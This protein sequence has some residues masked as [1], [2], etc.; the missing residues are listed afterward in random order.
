MTEDEGRSDSETLFEL[1]EKLNEWKHLRDLPAFQDF[2][3]QI[4]GQVEGREARILAMEVRSVEDVFEL[5]M[6]KGERAGMKLVS[7]YPDA[8]IEQLREDVDD[9]SVEE[10]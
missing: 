8:V 9:A 3:E 5:L 10:G 6:L 1:Q 7:L 4:Q 2:L